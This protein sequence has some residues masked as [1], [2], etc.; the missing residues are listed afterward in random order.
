MIQLEHVKKT[1]LRDDGTPVPALRDITCMIEAGEFVTVRGA[2][3][4][5][6]SSLLNILGCLDTLTSGLYRLAGEDV[7]GY[8]DKERS[9]VRARRIGFVFQ[10]CGF[11][12]IHAVRK[13]F[14]TDDFS[15]QPSA[16]CCSDLRDDGSR[17]QVVALERIFWNHDVFVGGN[18]KF[19]RQ[20]GSGETLDPKGAQQKCGGESND[21]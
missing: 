3:G 16:R 2:S 21:V 19:Q 14:E 7:S 10:V 5:G 18:R 4:S 8:S 12:K 15:S 20:L 13:E 11:V 1:Y 6:K 9:R 17:Q